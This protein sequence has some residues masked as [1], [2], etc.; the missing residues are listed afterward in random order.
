VLSFKACRRLLDDAGHPARLAPAIKATI[1][2]AN[3]H[4]L[5]ISIALVL[6]T[7]P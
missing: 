4:G 1:A 6:S 7:R 2:A 3:L 5:L